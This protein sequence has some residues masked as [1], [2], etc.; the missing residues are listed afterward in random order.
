MK[1]NYTENQNGN[2]M[3]IVLLVVGLIPTFG[4]LVVDELKDEEGIII[5]CTSVGLM[6]LAGILFFKLKTEVF[7]DRI[8]LS[9]G[10]GPIQKKIQ[11]SKIK[12]V[13]VVRNKWIYGWG[14]RHYGKG[15]LWNISGLD[16]IEISFNDRKSLFRIGSQDPQKLKESIEKLIIMND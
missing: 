3:L 8:K 12:D 16:A 6:M 5:A 15:W 10:I 13:R 11:L 1:A 7:E 14:I 4:L 2:W 9:F